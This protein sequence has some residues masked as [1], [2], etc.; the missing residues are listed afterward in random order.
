MFYLTPGHGPTH[1]RP[2]E[3]WPDMGEDIRTGGRSDRHAWPDMRQ[4]LFQMTEAA[5]QGTLAVVELEVGA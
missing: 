4:E 2:R 1:H 5:E 3:T